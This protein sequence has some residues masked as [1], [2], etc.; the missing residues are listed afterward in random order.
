MNGIFGMNATFTEERLVSMT[1]VNGK[2]VHR[3]MTIAT[4]L[5]EALQRARL[6]YKQPMLELNGWGSRRLPVES[7]L[8][9]G[10]YF[11]R[12]SRDEG[13]RHSLSMISSAR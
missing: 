8:I 12:S 11:I 2:T 4:S 13:H 10:G 6:H 9:G 3:C 1:L 7:R 5:Q